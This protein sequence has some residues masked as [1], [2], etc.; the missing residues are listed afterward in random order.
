MRHAHI[1]HRGRRRVQ[2]SRTEQALI[3]IALPVFL[4]VVVAYIA[5]SYAQ[6]TYEI[7]VVQMFEA[8]LASLVRISLAYTICLVVGVSLG[9]FSVIHPSIERVMLPV[10]D[11][12]ESLPVLV[13]FPVIIAVFVALGG[14]WLAA[15]IIMA[16]SMVWNILFSTVGG[17]HLIPEEVR[18]L[19]TVFGLSKWQEFKHIILP[20][21]IPSLITGSLLAWAEGWNMLM[22]AEVMHTYIPR[23]TEADDLFGIGSILVHATAAGHMHM[24][25]VAVGIMIAV[26]AVMNLLV[27]QPLLSYA[28][29]FKFE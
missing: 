29:K 16:L 22:V 3:H 14:Y 2:L 7:S 23:A 13:F 25:V 27:W 11:V 17:L 10:W 21:V 12:L 28:E 4:I 19:G 5:G 8:L 20:A 15:V 24:F 1:T 18:S 9:L 26:V 6:A